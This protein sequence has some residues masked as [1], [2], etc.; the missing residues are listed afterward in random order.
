MVGKIKDK[1]PVEY[2]PNG[3]RTYLVGKIR[4]RSPVKYLLNVKRTD[5]VGKMSRVVVGEE[6]SS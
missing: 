4:D 2:L 5:L 1:S 6:R 3:K